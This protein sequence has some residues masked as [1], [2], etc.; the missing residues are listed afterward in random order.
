MAKI[1]LDEIVKVIETKNPREWTLSRW[2]E[3]NNTWPYGRQD[4]NEYYFTQYKSKFGN[5]EVIIAKIKDDCTSRYVDC[6]DDV[7]HDTT[8][9][10]YKYQ[11][12]LKEGKRVLAK[13][14]GEKAMKAYN[15]VLR[16][17]REYNK[18]EKECS[19]KK[20]KGAIR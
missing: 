8:T 19:I 3:T 12:K 17:I 15:L 1:T 2:E 5:F 16:K 20:F 11:L 10:T 18:K 7:S 9:T 4:W 6:C 14:G 13:F